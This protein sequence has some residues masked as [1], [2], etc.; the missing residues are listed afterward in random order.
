MN[1]E[2]PQATFDHH[3]QQYVSAL[4]GYVCRL[5]EAFKDAKDPRLDPRTLF[6]H[7]RGA[8]REVNNHAQ[9]LRQ[10]AA[11]ITPEANRYEGEFYSGIADTLLERGED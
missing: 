9:T 11:Q 1:K 7:V 5:K 3:F 2:S 6:D 10:L 4:E 8:R